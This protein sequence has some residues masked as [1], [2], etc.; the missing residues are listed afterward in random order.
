MPLNKFM[1]V[2]TTGKLGLAQFMRMGGAKLIDVKA[3]PDRLF[4]FESEKTGKEWRIAYAESPFSDFN[5][6][7]MELINIAKDE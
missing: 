3:K 1:R 2:V 7:L 5:T 4:V 6:G